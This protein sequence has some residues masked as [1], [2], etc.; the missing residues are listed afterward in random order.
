MRDGIGLLVKQIE[1]EHDWINYD[2]YENEMPKDEK[3]CRKCSL[4]RK[5]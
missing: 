2:S 5:K 4:T 3:Y 1:C